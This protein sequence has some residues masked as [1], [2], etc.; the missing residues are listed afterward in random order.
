MCIHL[1][2]GTWYLLVMV[3]AGEDWSAFRN[4][5]A[6]YFCRR[7]TGACGVQPADIILHSKTKQAPSPADTKFQGLEYMYIHIISK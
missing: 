1:A 3:P 5:Q 6:P 2:L 4:Q 7:K